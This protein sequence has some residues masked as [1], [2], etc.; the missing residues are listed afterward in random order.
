[1]TPA[2]LA[3][4]CC[5][6]ELHTSCL[7]LAGVVV[8]G[9]PGFQRGGL[10]L[11]APGFVDGGRGFAVLPGRVDVGACLVNGGGRLTRGSG[12][13]DTR[14]PRASSTAGAAP[15][16]GPDAPRASCT[17]AA[18]GPPAGPAAGPPVPG[19]PGCP[20]IAPPSS[21]GAIPSASSG[22][23]GTGALFGEIHSAR[24]CGLL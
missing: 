20:P 19:M 21:G 1:M 2:C 15:P 10:R 17:A 11:D 3:V 14:T 7:V 4:E 16:D 12:G 9:R 18:A 24:E 22:S 5:G 13:V 6:G 8:D 23:F